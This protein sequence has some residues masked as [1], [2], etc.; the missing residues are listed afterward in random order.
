MRRVRV[1]IPRYCYRI[2]FF[3]IRFTQFACY[4]IKNAIANSYSMPYLV[5]LFWFNESLYREE[6]HNFFTTFSWNVLADFIV[7]KSFK[8]N[9]TERFIMCLIK[10]I[11]LLITYTH[12]I[13]LTYNF[14]CD[15][16]ID[17][18][19]LKN[20]ESYS[21]AFFS[22][23]GIGSTLFHYR[24]IHLC[25]RHRLSEKISIYQT[26]CFSY[27]LITE[28]ITLQKFRSPFE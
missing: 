1:V 13:K 3:S 6:L 7:N 23:F 2:L 27:L 9:F 26:K 22:V 8:V 18:F 28:F 20:V 21:F 4:K 11:E 16:V 15:R 14:I 10:L 19:F 25:I 5:N 24:G 12:H 17:V